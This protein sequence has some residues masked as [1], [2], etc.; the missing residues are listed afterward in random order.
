MCKSD[1]FPSVFVKKTEVD[2]CLCECVQLLSH[3]WMHVHALGSHVTEKQIN[4]IGCL[5]DRLDG[6]LHFI[7]FFSTNALRGICRNE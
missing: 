1:L 2:L 7:V 5:L 4:V 6:T 3:D